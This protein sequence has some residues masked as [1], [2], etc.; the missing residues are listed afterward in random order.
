M[1][2]AL[3]VA[4]LLFSVAQRL[5]DHP[6]ITDTRGTLTYRQWSMRA[7]GLARDMTDHGARPGD[8]VV[9]FMEN[10]GEFLEVLLAAWTAGLVAVPVNAKLHAL[11]VR[12]CIENCGARLAFTTAN[13]LAS[14]SA[15][16]SD[17]QGAR[18]ICAGSAEYEGLTRATELSV[19][20][21]S[22]SDPAWI[23]YT[24]GTT[25]RPKGAVLTNRNLIFLS[26]T[27]YADVDT[28]DERDTK[29][30]AA[31][32]SHGSGLYGLP[33]LLKGSH[34]VVQPGFDIDAIFDALTR[35]ERVTFFTVPTMLTRMVNHPGIGNARLENLKTIYY[36]GG[37]T[38][39]ADLKRAVHLFGPRLFQLYGQGETPMTGTGLRKDM[40]W[41]EDWI[42]T[43]GIPRSGVGIRVVD[44]HDREL[45]PGEIGEIITRSDCVMSCYWGDPDATAKA[46]RGGWLH[47]GD[48]GSVCTK[49]FLTLHDRSKD[50]IISGGTNIYPRE[51]EEVLLLHPGV[52]EVSAV[53]MP[54]PD[55]GETVVAFIAVKA[56]HTVSAAELDTL[57]LAHIARFK[58]PK[59][60]RFENDL[61]KNSYGKILKTELRKRLAIEGD[62]S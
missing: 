4:S 50:V 60:Y 15:A 28:V 42:T 55:W 26:Q 32:L 6:A 5:P 21:R 38:Y 45:P 31:P 16:M 8:R 20:E 29:L 46:I 18:L 41:N 34:Q 24:S 59:L 36:G 52:F 12:Y 44:D 43:C 33:F 57:C 25:G 49:G 62:L 39:L 11:E 10:C 40:H 51:V 47:T 3:N 14:I 19:V 54:D 53:G 27:Y 13:L 9:I 30:H 7:A 48:L 2:R 1:G 22:L 56:G 35:Y 58:R 23:F 61:P 37:P 17:M